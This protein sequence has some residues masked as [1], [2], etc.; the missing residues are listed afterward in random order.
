MDLKR[1]LNIKDDNFDKSIMTFEERFGVYEKSER[2]Y[3]DI[4]IA[5]TIT[6][7]SA[8]EKIIIT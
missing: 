5:P 7:A 2:C 6:V 1:L 4:G 8:D 3:L